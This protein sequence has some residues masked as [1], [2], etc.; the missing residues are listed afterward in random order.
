MAKDFATSIGPFACEQPS[1]ILN[2]FC[3]PQN[4]DPEKPM[5]PIQAS[6]RSVWPS[7]TPLNS[8][9]GTCGLASIPVILSDDEV[10]FASAT[11]TPSGQATGFFL[12]K[13]K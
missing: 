4:M 8:N 13:N 11:R 1:T 12:C 6:G 3:E 10:T 7:E 2:K 5:G 9:A